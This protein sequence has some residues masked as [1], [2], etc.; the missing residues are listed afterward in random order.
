MAVKLL[1]TL[2]GLPFIYYGEEIGMTGDKPD[3]R[4]RTPMQWSGATNA[5]FTKGSPWEKLQADWAT[6]NVAAQEN[7]PNSL[8]PLTRQLI[9]L[10]QSNAAL[11]TGDLVPVVASNGAVAAYLRRAKGSIVLV[12]A[13]LGTVPLTH[14]TITSTDAALPP[15]Q[16]TTQSLD[17]GSSGATV[18]VRSDGRILSYVPFG[19][20]GPMESHILTLSRR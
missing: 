5:G 7:D 20:L 3:E 14:V 17:G 11:G 6:T 12:I 4:L 18:S 10:R 9:H 19:V 2:P 13:N 8:L 16:Y 1:L 15:G